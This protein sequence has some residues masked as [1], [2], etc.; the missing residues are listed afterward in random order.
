MS[1]GHGLSDVRT[2]SERM[3][4][5]HDVVRTGSPHKQ[6]LG[7]MTHPHSNIISLAKARTERARPAP[8]DQPTLSARAYGAAD[9][10]SARAP[11]QPMAQGRHLRR[12][13]SRPLRD[14]AGG[15]GRQGRALQRTGMGTR[16]C[17]RASAPSPKRKPG[18][19]AGWGCSA[20]PKLRKLG[21]SPGRP[22]KPRKKKKPG[23]FRRRAVLTDQRLIEE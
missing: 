21:C 11:V 2:M 22:R 4:F 16:T 5:G 18:R 17:R 12:P 23:A 3:S 7:K 6:E 13:P 9:F 20:S 10:A 8:A 19:K 15:L 1:F 14:P